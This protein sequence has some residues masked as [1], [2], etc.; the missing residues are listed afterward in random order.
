M[1]PV[2]GAG[3]TSVGIGVKANLEL[4]NRIPSKGD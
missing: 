2:T 4:Q 1:N 3:R